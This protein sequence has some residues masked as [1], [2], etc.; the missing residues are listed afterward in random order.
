MLIPY[1]MQLNFLKHEVLTTK[2]FASIPRQLQRSNVSD[3]HLP[4]TIL[5]IFGTLCITSCLFRW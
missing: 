4:N 1:Y 5:T 3:I 2:S